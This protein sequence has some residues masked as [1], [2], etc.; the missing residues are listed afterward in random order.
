MPYLRFPPEI[1]DHIVDF[2]HNDLKT[3]RKCCL[4]SKL[5]VP[6]A[7]KHIFRA[8]RFEHRAHIEAWRK[9]FPDRTNSPA[10]YTRLLRIQRPEV[11]DPTAAEDRGLFQSFSNVVRL[12]VRSYGTRNRRFGSPDSS[13]LT[14]V[15]I[16]AVGILSPWKTVDLVCSFPLLKDLDIKSGTVTNSP[17]DHHTFRPA[18]SPPLT[19]TLALSLMTEIRPTVQSLL[20]LP[21][22]LHFRK[23][24][25]VWYRESDPRWITTLVGKC[26]ETLECVD[27]CR[28]LPRMSIRFL[29]WNENPI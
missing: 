7:R 25:W 17:G 26:A 13:R 24:V 19:G 9:V 11:V 5:W 28:Y 4:V 29:F 23:F 12:E 6:R 16:T 8:V 3:L 2:L 21:N 22:G 27:F 20:D 1:F 15:E 14:I 18:T 10:R